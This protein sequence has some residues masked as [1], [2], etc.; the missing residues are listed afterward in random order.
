MADRSVKITVGANV[1]PLKSAMA[2]GSKAVDGLAKKS[3]SLGSKIKSGLAMA[4]VTGGVLSLGAAIKGTFGLGLDFTTQLNTLQA[5]SGATAAQMT[6]VSDK[7]QALGNDIEIP[8]TSASDAAEAMTELAKGGLSVQQAMDA[9]KGTLQL[10]AAAGVSGAQAATIQANA[11]NTFSLKASDAGHVAD[12]LANTANAASGEITDFAQGMQQAG[13]VASLFGVSLDDTATVLGLFAK[14]G[15]IGSDAGTSLKTALT[16]L[17]TPSKNAQAAMD[18]LNLT[19]YDSQGKF[20]GMRS[21]TDQLSRAQANM[22]QQAFQSAAGILFG[23]DAIRAA[24]FL[25]RAGV[26]GYDEMHDAIEKTGGAAALAAA[27]MK[28][29]PGALQNLQN[30]AENLAIELYQ[31]LAPTVEAVVNGVSTAISDLTPIFAGTFGVASDVIGAVVTVLGNLPGPVKTFGIA[32]AGL[33]LANKIGLVGKLSSAFGRVKGSVSGFGSSWARIGDDAAMA[34]VSRMRVGIGLVGDAAKKAGTSLVGAFGGPWGIALA[35][36][37]AAIDL[38]GRA[39][40]DANPKVTDFSG[41]IDEN[42]GA[43]RDNAGQATALALQKAFDPKML[44]AYGLTLGDVTKA[45]M[46]GGDAYAYAKGKID[47]WQV[48]H[49]RDDL[50]IRQGDKDLGQLKSSRKQ[51]A[52]T[53]AAGKAVL[54]ASTDAQVA[55]TDATNDSTTATVKASA[56]QN[57]YTDWLNQRAEAGKNAADA[58]KDQSAWDQKVATQ[59]QKTAGNIADLSTKLDQSYQSAHDLTG[60]ASQLEAELARLSGRNVTVEQATYALNSAMQQMKDAAKDADGNVKMLGTGLIGANGSIKLTTESGRN[61]Y[62]NVTALAKAAQDQAYAVAE[63]TGKTKGQKAAEDAAA[64]SLAASRKQFID[65]AKQM[66]L[67][68]DQAKKLADRYF[69]IPKNIKTTIKGDFDDVTNKLQR[70]AD[71]T[72]VIPIK[73]QYMGSIGTP[74]SFT[75][76]LTARA[77]GGPVSG[78]R[79][80]VGEKGP[81]ILDLSSGS[82]GY[83]HNNATLNRA[84]AAGTLIPRANGGA[85]IGSQVGSGGPALNAPIVRNVTYNVYGVPSDSAD[86]LVAKIDR[87]SAFMER[88]GA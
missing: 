24:A 8:A 5:V 22:S 13:G 69:G 47:A 70:I 66:G 78:G 84:V 51:Y 40:A 7:A 80:L 81:E 60:Q 10:A 27:K 36:A 4:G 75:T 18:A 77:S 64:K 19:V 28:G 16:Q 45:V 57:R 30:G 32:L 38:L 43:L 88:V 58:A 46:Q 67:T 35:A 31:K 29:L 87:K 44:Q 26:Q 74:A 15:V 53:I 76:G 85:V 21:L 37:P 86:T 41:A 12:V 61:L 82:R 2:D 71:T 68:A 17:A 34:G 62:D 42:T 48:A 73:G 20:V 9:A 72:V 55:S 33:A 79:Y 52:D 6:K 83:V 11:L 14:A 50:A 1:A 3:Q 25:A 59:A 63:A 23:N 39:F 49:Q 56:A 54:D 65:N